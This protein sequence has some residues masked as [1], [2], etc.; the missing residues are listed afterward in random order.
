MKVINGQIEK[1]VIPSQA[2]KEFDVTRTLI[3]L[4][5]FG[6]CAVAFGTNPTS[7]NENK[8][9]ISKRHLETS[10]EHLIK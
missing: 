2:A 7:D 5:T 8:Y 9:I 4:D 6:D 1:V 10:I 3:L